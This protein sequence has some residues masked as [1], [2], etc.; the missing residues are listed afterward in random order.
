MPSEEAKML[1]TIIIPVY[2]EMES[3]PALMARLR[4]V[5]REI[6]W[7]YELIF[8]NDGSTDETGKILQNMA[9]I[10]HRI[11]VLTF[12][13]NFG[14]QAA[15]TAGLD[16]ADGDAAA[17]IDADL[18]DPP[19]LLPEMLG[20]MRQG[21]DVVSAQRRARPGDGVWK[22][23]TASAFYWF[24]RRFVDRRLTPEV[25]DFRLFSRKA[26]LAL[27]GFREQH[28]FMRGLVAWLGLKEVIVPFHR[29]SRAYGSTKYPLFKMLQLAWVAVSSFSA[30]PLRMSTTLGMFVTLFGVGYFLYSIFTAIVAKTAI[31]GWTSLV[32]LQIVFSGTIL[33]A[34]GVLGNY[35][36][37]IY[38]ESKQRPLYVVA[39]LNN[40]EIGQTLP[41][42]GVVLEPSDAAA[43]IEHA[44]APIARV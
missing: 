37:R 42:R 9:V 2:N 32:C 15:V 3:L 35:V 39:E 27:R 10:D 5:A 18:Q 17:V 31:P 23:S 41:K 16:F 34:V 11:K 33:T 14:H 4:P 29:E 44:T 26:V 22:R 19:E 13:R 6:D 7:D 30:L 28:R 20:L 24:M 36:A 40:I 1:L 12:S 25:G 38:E 43:P 21:Y 8:V